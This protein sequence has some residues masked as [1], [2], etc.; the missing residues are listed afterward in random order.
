[1]NYDNSDNLLLSGIFYNETNIAGIQFISTNNMDAFI[2][3]YGFEN[4]SDTLDLPGGL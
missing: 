4:K 2:L 1:M 3:K